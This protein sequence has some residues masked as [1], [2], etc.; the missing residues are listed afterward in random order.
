M[1]EVSKAMV[2]SIAV[3]R[4]SLPAE[5]KVVA[6]ANASEAEVEA[7]IMAKATVS[8]AEGHVAK[9][10]SVLVGLRAIELCKTVTLRACKLAFARL[11]EVSEITEC[12]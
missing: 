10:T 2:E 3:E 6:L 9:V 12:R 5:T 8:T 4:T 7:C 1:P 11:T